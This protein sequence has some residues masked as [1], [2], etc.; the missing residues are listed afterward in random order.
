M[1]N[2]CT[3]F[4]FYLTCTS[5]QGVSGPW[6]PTNRT[7][8]PARLQSTVKELWRPTMGLSRPWP[9]ATHSAALLENWT[10]IWRLLLLRMLSV[11]CFLFLNA[12]NPCLKSAP[13][14]SYLSHILTHEFVARFESIS[15]F[16]SISI[17]CNS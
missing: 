13:C 1:L 16:L 10:G 8:L 9:W 4:F 6:M 15:V 2:V 12:G 14:L 11:A 7:L 17:F 5:S 3:I